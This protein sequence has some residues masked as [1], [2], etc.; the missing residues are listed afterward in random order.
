MKS[1]ELVTWPSAPPV[2]R[3]VDQDRR[4]PLVAFGEV[5]VKRAD[6][7]DFAPRAP[8]QRVDGV[9]AGREQ[10][11]SA[12]RA[13][14]HPVPAGIPVGHPR[15]I[16][17]A[18]EPQVAEPPGRP[19]PPREHQVRV[20]AQLE[21]HDRPHP[22]GTDRVADPHQL[23]PRRARSASRGR[24]ACRP[25]PRPPPARRGGRSGVAIEMMSTS[26]ASSRSSYRVVMRAS[27]SD[28]L[29]LL[30]RGPH[31][32]RCRGRAAT[33]PRRGDSSGRRRCAGPRTSRPRTRPHP[34]FHFESAPA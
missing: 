25:A 33:S 5:R 12:A 13:R 9:A 20:V 7:D 22:R 28:R 17:R 29:V 16:L 18:R 3:G 1:V 32:R 27:G 11:A 21:G 31:P 8:A 30:E 34:V 24:C 6:F 4:R 19:Q 23:L 15:Q 14:A 2:E 26:G 10:V